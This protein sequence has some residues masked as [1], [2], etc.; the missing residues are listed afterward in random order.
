[1][2]NRLR[3]LLVPS[4][5]NGTLTAGDALSLAMQLVMNAPIDKKIDV[6]SYEKAVA[7][8]LNT[9]NVF[10]LGAGRMAL[11]L[12]LKCLELEPEAE[13]ILP[14]YTCVV[15]PNAVRFAGFRPRYVDIRLSDFNLDPAAL[16]AAISAK[17]RAVL[18]QHTFGIPADI[19]AVQAI[20]KRHNLFLIEDG[21]HALGASYRGKPIGCWG[22]A[23]FFSTETSKMISTDKGGLLVT[24]D[25]ALAAKI[26]TLYESLPIRSPESERIACKRVIYNVLMQ[27]QWV[28]LLERLIRRVFTISIADYSR[29]KAYFSSHWSEYE[30]ELSGVQFDL[31]PRRLAGILCRIGELQV[32]RL[33]EDVKKRN[34]KAA[35]LAEI[36]PKFGARVPSY[37][38]DQC[39]PSFVK[40]PFLVEDRERWIKALNKLRLANSTWLNDPLHP[41]ETRCHLENRYEWGSC[42]NAEYASQHILNLPVGRSVS[43]SMLARLKNLNL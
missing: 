26:R 16:E 6:K 14:G 22:D 18:M 38:L 2:H 40:Y 28:N 41:R 21:A 11:Y 20:C 32:Y 29:V 34:E 23:A 4:F 35:F 31:Y 15:M 1:M 33:K 30:A 36:L 27:D 37:D 19:M 17:T 43:F 7:E 12:L 42:P 24:S 9:P 39:Y 10:A 3:H 5:L 25:A 8:A 13:V